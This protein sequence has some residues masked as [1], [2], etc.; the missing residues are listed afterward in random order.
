[1]LKDYNL[2]TANASLAPI[3]V[4]LAITDYVPL[5]FPDTRLIPTES[6]SSIAK[7]SVRPAKITPQQLVHLAIAVQH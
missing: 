2:S 3:I 5:V 7:L 1:V 6:V 4:S